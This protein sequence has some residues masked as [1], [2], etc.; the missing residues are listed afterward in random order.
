MERID[1]NVIETMVDRGLR[2]LT[3]TYQASTE[4]RGGW[5]HRLDSPNPGPSATASGLAGFRVHGHS[6]EHE[7]ACLR[8]LRHRQIASAD[9]RL[10][11]GWAVNTSFGQPVIEAT[12]LV[13]R[14]LVRCGLVLAAEGPDVKRASEWIHANQNDDGGWGPL[15]AQDSRVWL[16]AMATR[17]VAT[18][19]PRSAALPAAVAWLLNARDPTTGAWGEVDRQPPS[20]THTAYALTALVESGVGNE[21][22]AAA[23]AIDAAYDWLGLAFDPGVVHD[24]RARME[25]YNV[26][27]VAP[28]GRPF[29]WQST[30]WHPGACPSCCRRW[31]DNLERSGSTWS[32]RP[33]RPCE[34]HNPPRDAGRVPTAPPRSPYGVSR[35]SS[36]RWRTHERTCRCVRAASS[37]RCPGTRQSSRAAPISR[38]LPSGS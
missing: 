6:F 30:I 34:R 19:D 8:F 16:T 24:D 5:Y 4:H 3:R 26:V 37:L 21:N 10:D 31:C 12:G 17:A 1:G 33:W 23:E 38:S 20:V 18:V 2:L 36:T 25:S 35:R 9:R 7:T 11:G 14:L 15:A 29:T 32:P 22:R 13:T 27:G 28:D